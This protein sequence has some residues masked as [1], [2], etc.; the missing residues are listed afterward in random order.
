[1][2]HLAKTHRRTLA[3]C[4]SVVTTT[5]VTALATASAAAAQDPRADALAQGSVG[6][7][8]GQF[9]DQPVAAG[10]LATCRTGL[11]SEGS[12]GPVELE[13]VVSFEGGA[14]SCE[15]DEAGELARTV[16]EGG[17][18]RF[19]G[20]RPHG[21]PRIRI[22]NFSARCDTTATGTNSWVHFSGL[23]GLRV[24]GELPANHVVP[25]PGPDGAPIA[26]VTFNETTASDGGTTVN[27]M[28]VRMFPDGG[29]ATGDVVV[30]TVRC[31]PAR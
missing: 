10:P 26:T 17:H 5:L 22:R 28:H 2:T 15:I 18:V 21:G 20:L 11:L 4:L 23:S 31:V 7:V 9:G 8:R 25:V 27:L 19:D 6:W 13:G 30:G 16:V 14:S 29:P 3:A 24:P 1:M 12:S